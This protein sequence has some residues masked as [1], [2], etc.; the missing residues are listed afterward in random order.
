MVSSGTWFSLTQ[1]STLQVG[2]P[3]LEF[4]DWRDCVPMTPCIANAIISAQITKLELHGVV[5]NEDFAIDEGNWWGETWGLRS[6]VLHVRVDGRVDGP[7][8]RN[9]Y[10]F[11]TSILK[12]AASSLKE[13]VWLGFRYDRN[14]P[15]HTFG[16]DPVRFP[17]L[18]KL[19]LEWILADEVLWFSLISA[20]KDPTLT[21]LWVDATDT[22]FA[23]FLERRGNIA[24]LAKVTWAYMTHDCLAH[25]IS[26]IASNPQV[27]SFRHQMPLPEGISANQ[28][29]NPPDELQQ[30]LLQILSS[31]SCH[32]LKSL[33][34]TWARPAIPPSALRG[35]ARVT[36]L[37]HLWLQAGVFRH[38]N[39]EWHVDHETLRRLLCPLKQLR[40]LALTRDSYA[41]GNE[42]LDGMSRPG[43]G[44]EHHGEMVELAGLFA[45]SHPSLEWMYFEQI[46]MTVGRI[47]GEVRVLTLSEQKNLW[48]LLAQMWGQYCAN[49]VDDTR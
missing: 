40:W 4:L 35:L 29:N 30:E 6:L 17:M 41:H 42:Y 24:T 14:D 16:K 47:G 15:K 48:S 39:P 2:L 25:L 3:R 36:T 33:A 31:T 45:A 27:Q 32:A 11:T 7:L 20:N 44:D 23:A 49:W 5:L 26:F 19:H 38:G 46:A 12:L 8:R 1:L 21:E 37:E 34:L 43:D 9:A 22:D 28:P 10:K 18:K 13:L